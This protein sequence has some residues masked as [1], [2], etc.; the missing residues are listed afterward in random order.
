MLH[1]GMLGI[2]IYFLG[3]WNKSRGKLLRGE[4]YLGL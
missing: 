1:V 4:S 2:V 3:E